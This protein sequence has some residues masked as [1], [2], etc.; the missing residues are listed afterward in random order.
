LA[1]FIIP[2]EC[3]GALLRSIPRLLGWQRIGEKSG[4]RLHSVGDCRNCFNQVV[5]G[6]LHWMWPFCVG[7][8]ISSSIV[9][10]LA[11]A[12]NGSKAQERGK[13]HRRLLGRMPTWQG[14]ARYAPAWELQ[15]L[16]LPCGLGLARL[17]TAP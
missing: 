3:L 6:R 7:Q 17:D 10:Y 5:S 15:L 14:A 4:Q 12:I 1:S 16:T 11:L 13:A 9:L 8:L 2:M